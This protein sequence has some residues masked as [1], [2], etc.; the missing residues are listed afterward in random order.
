[1]DPVV[2]DLSAYVVAGAVSTR[3]QEGRF[4]TDSRTPAQGIEDGEAAEA[5]GF[6]R[7]WLSERMDIKLADVVLSGI[8]ARTSRLEL[9]T[10]LV[11]PC[12]R[13]P[14]MMAAMAGTLQG[15]YGPRVVL[16]LG[17]GDAGWFRG[18]GI[19]IPSYRE[20][21][22]YIEVMPTLWRGEVVD[23]D[24]PLGRF[25]GIGH[26]ETFHGPPPPVW[27]GGF[28]NPRGARLVAEH[29]DGVML[30]PMMTASAVRAAVGRVREACQAIGRDP[31]EVRICAPVVTAPELD[32]EE[33]RQLAHGRSVTYLSV[34]G[35]GELLCEANG[36]DHS[37]LD[38]IRRH[39][40]L[41][42]LREIADK[43]FQRH[44]LMDVA[45][46]VPD[47]LMEECSA[48]GSVASCAAKVQA[49]RDAGADEVATYGS[50]PQQNAGLIRAWRAHRP[51]PTH[52][53]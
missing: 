43:S 41:A 13:H 14:W 3:P 27:F 21:G 10:G 8:G 24:G 46:V 42:G 38:A 47:E 1:M 18:T 37:V 15:C 45:A 51:I 50:T 29:C 17:R 52:A 35:Y 7:V 36:W 6:H 26:A 11:D 31:A 44:Q 12:T 48:L 53:A 16:G 34:P 25:D 23:Y 33:A 4:E 39:P 19:R 30:V 32:D 28:A 5:L 9:G 40:K 2:E 22:D 20:L 49:F